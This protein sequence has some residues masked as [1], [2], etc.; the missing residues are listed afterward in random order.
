GKSRRGRREGKSTGGQ[1]LAWGTSRRGGRTAP[2]YG[3]ERYRCQLAAWTGTLVTM[4][5]S[6]QRQ[7]AS[8]G[9]AGGQAGGQFGVQDVLLRQLDV[10]GHTDEGDL[11][12]VGVEEA[13]AGA[14]IAIARLPR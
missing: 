1:K 9:Q 14:W 3:A 5:K 6:G 2:C 10:V 11:V 13:E 4:R 12:G 7:S 8:I